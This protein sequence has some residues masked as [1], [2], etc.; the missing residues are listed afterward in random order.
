MEDITSNSQYYLEVDNTDLATL[1]GNVATGHKLGRTSVILK[2][3]NVANNLE[4]TDSIPSIQ[5]TLTISRPDKITINLLPHY[6]W[7]TV[8]GE[9]H[10]IS[11][12]LYTNDN[13]LITLGDE[14]SIA[15]QY[16]EKI[17]TPLT[18]TV[19]GSHIF[20]EAINTGTSAVFGSFEKLK[21]TAE[22]Q[23]FEKLELNPSIV[24]LPYDPNHLRRQKIQYIANGGDGL[25]SWSSLNGNLIGINQ[26]GLAETRTGNQASYSG[27]DKYERNLTDFAQIK[28]ALQRNQK[29]SKMADIFFLP[30]TKLEIVRYNFE[31]TLKD[32]VY[33]H[34]A[35]YAEH[36]GKLVSLTSCDN[37]HF[38]YD[39]LEDIFH[40]VDNAELPA[41][42]QLH[43]SACH[44]VKLQSH[45]LGSS[46]FKISYTVFDRVLYADVNLM[47]FEKL[48]ILNPI[49]NEIVLPIGA[50]RNV[51]YQNGPQKVF[52]IDAELVKNIHI[53]QSIASVAPISN[54]YAADKHILNV[55]C[56]K[57][58]STVLTF[59]IYNTLSAS[60]HVPYVSKFETHVHCVK[61]RFI[62]LY[63]AEKLRQGCPLKM[64][65]S[66]MHV[67]EN[68]N[69]IDITIEVLDAQN[70][71]LQN[72]SSLVLS[73]QFLQADDNRLNYDIVYERKSDEDIVAGVK[74]PKRDF[75]QTTLP[76]VHNAFKIKASVDRYDQVVLYDESISS[77]S[78]EFGIPQ[79]GKLTDDGNLYKPT[80]EN[81][82]NFLAV[83][84]TLLPFD[85]VS[86]FLAPNHQ[87]RI[88]LIQGSGFYELKVNELNIINAVI[89]NESRQI[90]IEPLRIGQVQVDIVDRC[91]QTEPSRLTVS[92]VSIGRIEVQVCLYFIFSIFRKYS[93]TDSNQKIKKTDLSTEN[94]I[95]RCIFLLNS[96]LFFVYFRLLIVLKKRKPSK[97][98]QSS[99][100]RS[101]IHWHWTMTI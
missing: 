41:G 63:T 4:N 27:Y 53:D 48:D 10:T 24:F 45:G 22:L 5:A 20:G 79:S 100:T 87:Q 60:N 99:T 32:Y 31:T 82:L 28:V 73:W 83:N 2:D 51:I 25:Y 33:L 59:D 64:K 58:G 15:S 90:I 37:L 21:A 97:P 55:L 17:F 86:I 50:S 1:D 92:V 16:D 70:R 88:Q 95:L 26:N 39:M 40:K 74:V 72:I 69:Q 52:N 76:E 7:L 65:N 66:L 80:I 46:H 42:E 96:E 34:V 85:S 6:N 71:K 43:P 67:R 61:P 57:V 101:T 81:E 29:I 44:L 30:P 93:Q 49:S 77:E 62:S 23:V 78:P 38:E 8:K 54:T 75:L 56:R 19:N 89:D 94:I 91:L 35:L 14:Y 12:N 36:D 68:D 13:Q 3:R 98:L 9:Q 18:S 84:S 47:V 11:L